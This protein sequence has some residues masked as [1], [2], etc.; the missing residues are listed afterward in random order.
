M[1]LCRESQRLPRIGQL[2]A[3]HKIQNVSSQTQ[4]VPKFNL[5]PEPM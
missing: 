4:M 5:R 2:F 3:I 1:A